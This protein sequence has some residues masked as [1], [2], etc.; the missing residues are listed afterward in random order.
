MTICNHNANPLASEAAIEDLIT[1]AGKINVDGVGV[2]VNTSMTKNTDS[3]EQLTTRIGRLQMRRCGS[4][5]T[6]TIFVIYAP[7]SSYE[8]VEVFCMDLEKF[9]REDHAFYNVIIGDFNAKIGP[10]RMPEE[11]HIKTH[12]V[13]RWRIP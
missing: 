12:G 9:Y 4:T 8:E 11:L 10:V 13:T 2:L 3:F 6:L 7:I 5:P 1:Q